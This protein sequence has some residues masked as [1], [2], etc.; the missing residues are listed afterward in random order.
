M[1]QLGVRQLSKSQV[2]EMVAHLHAQVEAFRNRPLDSGHYTAVWMDALTMK[3][4]E[5]GRTVNVPVW[6]G[7]CIPARAP[8]LLDILLWPTI[9]RVSGPLAAGQAAGFRGWRQA[10]AASGGG[11]W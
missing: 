3:V 1:E 9:A 2:S 6:S 10:G 7:V 8:R 4:R 5:A 11:G